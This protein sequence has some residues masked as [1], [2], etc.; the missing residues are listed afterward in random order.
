MLKR[1]PGQGRHPA[2]R[3]AYGDEFHPR[4][5]RSNTTFRSPTPARQ[6]RRGVPKVRSTLIV[7]DTALFKIEA[8]GF[9]RILFEHIAMA[10]DRPC[11]CPTVVDY[12]GRSIELQADKWKRLKSLKRRLIEILDPALFRTLPKH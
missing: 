11:G 1:S 8:A 10:G 7:T 5:N 9:R 12:R 6:H 3:C 2:D 4:G